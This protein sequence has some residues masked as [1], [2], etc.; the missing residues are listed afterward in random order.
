[1]AVFTVAAVLHV[2]VVLV[3]HT[4]TNGYALFPDAQGY[5]STSARLAAA[6]RNE[7]PFETRNLSGLVGSSVWGYPVIMALG[8]VMTGGGWLAAKTVLALLAAT[9]AVAAHGLALV[10]ARG[11]KRALV[12]GLMVGASPSLLLWDAWG[13]KDG[14]I[15]ALVLWALLVQ[16]RA[17]FSIAC[18]STMLGIYACLYLRPAAALFLALALLTRVRLRREYLAGSLIVVGAAALFILPRLMTLLG[19]V[20]SLEVHDGIRLGFTGGYGSKNVL[21]HPQ[22]LVALLLGPF[23]WAFGPET[24]VPGRWLYIGT[25]VWIACLAL[26]PTVLRRAWADTHGVGRAAVLGSAAYAAA[27]I[28]TFGGSFY[29]Q[30]SLLECVLIIL[31]VLYLPLSPAAAMMRIHVWLAFIAVVA[32]VHSPYLTPTIWSKLLAVGVIGLAVVLTLVCGHRWGT[33]RRFRDRRT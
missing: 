30:R 17:R 8:R 22:Y 3:V 16:T 24:A 15:V 1:M 19:L 33:V 20:E 11:R 25:V 31:V 26:A 13:L 28:A 32:V 27:Y 6:W 2:G 29:R 7:G 9:G 5:E 10:S 23:P 14:L 12:V 18:V 4:Q 21:N